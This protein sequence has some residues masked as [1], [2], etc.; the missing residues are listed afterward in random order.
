M[1]IKLDGE[2][3]TKVVKASNHNVASIAKIVGFT[4]ARIYQLMWKGG[5]VDGFAAKRL[6]RVLKVSLDTIRGEG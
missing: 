6:A 3:F 5:N 4:P 2:K 1:Y